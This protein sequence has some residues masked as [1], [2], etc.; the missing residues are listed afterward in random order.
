MDGLKGLQLLVGK[1]IK[2]IYM[3]EGCLKFETDSGNI[4]FT[5]DGDCCSQSVFYDFYGVKN[6]LAGNPVTGV[7]EVELNPGDIIKSNGDDTDK[8]SY[9][10]SIS[11]YGFQLFT[12][13]KDFGEV[14]SVFSFR[15]YSNGYYGGWME[16]T[17]DCIV[18]PEITDDVIETV[19]GGEKD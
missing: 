5:V 9:Q 4:A 10:E 16:T 7:R 2:K 17:G 13:S 19:R 1:T 6:L 11:A 3:N 12:Q 18:E 14:T 15:N 8:K